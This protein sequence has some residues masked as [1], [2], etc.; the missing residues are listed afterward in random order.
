VRREWWRPG[1]NPGEHFETGQDPYHIYDN[2]EFVIV[3]T[4]LDDSLKAQEMARNLVGS[5]RVAAVHVTRS[6]SFYFWDNDVRQATEFV[7]K[8]KTIKVNVGQVI[9][10]ISKD[11]PY[12]VPGIT[13]QFVTPK[14]LRYSDWWLKSARRTFVQQK[15]KDKEDQDAS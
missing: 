11:H 13:V 14:G 7:L 3:E 10:M 9:D 1:R 2:S 8:I 12:E 6:D 15:P 4:A 5:S